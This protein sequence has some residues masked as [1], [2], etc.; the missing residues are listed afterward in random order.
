VR[1]PR[2]ESEKNLLRSSGA[3]LALPCSCRGQPWITAMSCQ[4]G[5]RIRRGQRIFT[6]N[7][8]VKAGLAV[9][10]QAERTR[11]PALG[12]GFQIRRKDETYD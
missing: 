10:R 1:V 7:C 5:L 12:S 6:C 9:L 4:A 11:Q 8:L 3:A 2:Q